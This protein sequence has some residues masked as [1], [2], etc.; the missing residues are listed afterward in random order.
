MKRERKLFTLDDS[1]LISLEDAF[2]Y[3]EKKTGVLIDK[4]GDSRI[5]CDHLRVIGSFLIN[6]DK[7]KGTDRSI[8]GFKKFLAVAIEERLDLLFVGD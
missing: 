1:A 4:Y 6:A 5:Y 3:L 2:N 7:K 8:S